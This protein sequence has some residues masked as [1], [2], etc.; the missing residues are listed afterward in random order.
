MGPKQVYDVLPSRNTLNLRLQTDDEACERLRLD[1]ANP[2]ASDR[3]V[4][5][6][7]FQRVLAAIANPEPHLDDLLFARRERLRAPIRLFL[8]DSG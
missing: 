4:L 1:L 5:A 6:D 2:L 8:A 7:L 3:K